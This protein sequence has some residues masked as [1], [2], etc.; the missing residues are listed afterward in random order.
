MGPG[1]KNSEA[2]KERCSRMWM[3]NFLISSLELF[4]TDD[5][6]KEIKFFLMDDLRRSMSTF[7]MLVLRDQQFSKY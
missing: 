1:L 5:L 6:R 3:T 4:L 7:I 2:V